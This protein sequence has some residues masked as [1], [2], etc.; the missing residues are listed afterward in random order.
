MLS[1]V[2]LALFPDNLKQCL[3]ENEMKLIVQA[4]KGLIN[5]TFFNLNE[6][7]KNTNKKQGKQKNF[8][9]KKL[10]RA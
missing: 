1:I 4:A 7:L 5:L 9:N 2:V 3:Y 8:N 6:N 10:V